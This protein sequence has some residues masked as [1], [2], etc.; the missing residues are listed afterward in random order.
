QQS[1]KIL[2]VGFQSR[3]EPAL[4]AAK[5]FADSGF[6]GKPYY[7]EAVGMGVETGRRR[8]LPGSP[9]FISRT[10][11]GGG[12]T[13]DIGVYPLDS[14]LNI[15]NHPVPVSVNA[16]TAGYLGHDEAASKVAGAWV[17]DPAKFEVE[18][19]SAAFIRFEDDLVMV[20][21]Q[22]W[23]MHAESLGNP[24]VLGTKG[25]IS[26]SDGVPVFYTD[27]NGYMVN[28]TPQ[29][30]PRVDAFRQKIVD[31][32]EAVRGNKQSPIDPKGIVAMHYIIDAIYQSAEIKKEVSVNLPPA[33]RRTK[34]T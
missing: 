33:L 3:Y 9:T 19:F 14:S 30:L 2:M 12:V 21:K 29:H 32:V 8:G 23:A 17:W 4:V 27:V 13:L 6:L 34:W 20:Y 11:A 22:A 25:G 5:K 26:V 18:D 10:L 31:F 7:A 16:V 28:I 15:L 1:G 24:L